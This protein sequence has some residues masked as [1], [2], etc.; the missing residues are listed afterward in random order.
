MTGVQTCA[1]PICKQ[2]LKNGAISTFASAPSESVEFVLDESGELV[3]NVLPQVVPAGTTFSALSVEGIE[4]SGTLKKASKFVESS[5]YI[6]VL[7]PNKG[8]ISIIDPII[9]L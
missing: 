8:E 3:S 9:P 1:L 4:V 6:I 7:N 2:N 5:D